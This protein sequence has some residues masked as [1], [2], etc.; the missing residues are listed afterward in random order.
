MTNPNVFKAGYTLR[1][2]PD[3]DPYIDGDVLVIP[4]RL[5]NAVKAFWLWEY[6]HDPE[7]V[8]AEL[9]RLEE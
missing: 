9:L 8:L 3:C 5:E 6:P 7:R 4:Q 1:I 2:L